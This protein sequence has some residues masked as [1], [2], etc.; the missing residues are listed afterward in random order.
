MKKGGLDC[1]YFVSLEQS[2]EDKVRVRQ[3]VLR[4]RVRLLNTSGVRGVSLA[5]VRIGKI[6]ARAIWRPER[7]IWANV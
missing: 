1:T 5:H 6:V 2:L 4:K 7:I 3:L